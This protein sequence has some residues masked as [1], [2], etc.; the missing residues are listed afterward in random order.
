MIAQ[1]KS[2]VHLAQ[3]VQLSSYRRLLIVGFLFIAA[4]GIRLYHV[5]EPPLNFHATRQYRSLIIARGF[6]YAGNPSIRESSRKVARVSM[7]RQGL[8]EP[9]IV[10]F[11]VSTIYRIVGE[12]RFWIPRLVSSLFWLSG[13]IFLYLIVRRLADEVAAVFATAF[14]LFLPFAVIAS[15][16]FQPD[17]FMVMLLLA[18]IYLILRYYDAPSHWWLVS[19]AVVSAL[20][21]LVK[22]ISVFAV[23]AVF[24]SLTVWREGIRRVF[25]NAHTW[26]FV[27][28]SLLPTT[29]FYLYG[30]IGAGFLRTQAQ[31]S[32]VPQ[33]VFDP[34]FW[35]G[36]LSNIDQV[37]G[38]PVFV[39]ALVGLA[40]VRPG[41]P[42][43]TMIGWWAGYG[44]F[45]L[46]FS[47]H[48]ATHDYYHLQ[49]VPIVALSLGLMVSLVF[50]RVFEL[51][52]EWYWRVGVAGIAVLA[53]L[54]SLAV[55]GTRLV[56]PDFEKQVNAAIQIGSRVEHSTN[57][58]YLAS[59][60]GLSLEYHGE[61]SGRPWPLVSDLEWERLAG[62]P[63]LS[64]RQRFYTWFAKDSPEYFIVEDLNEFE[65]Q[66]EL[67][68]F[69]AA[70]YPIVAQKDNY[71]IFAL[72]GR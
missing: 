41:L 63:V 55:S 44:V 30:I 69:L 26:L 27:V 17:P 57:T 35:K 2:S 5:D 32:F 6:Y 42:R 34:F 61:L 56:N 23:L 29:V 1:F 37:V 40:L 62:L 52:R 58:V 20:T 13:C 11:L 18:S 36:W 68:E 54:L 19:M 60:Y 9:P 15:R 25:I 39:T 24:F 67:K 43:A 38:F 45:C 53:L 50:E 72:R 33:L 14:Y 47:Y 64:A 3:K 71:I 22:P 51:H 48:I 28:L 46:V 49:L 59:D 66:P 65:Q 21:F 8:L 4:L 7:E 70:N 31:S 10:E 16:S 12:E